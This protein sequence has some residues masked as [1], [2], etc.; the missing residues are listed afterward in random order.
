MSGSTDGPGLLTMSEVAHA[1]QMEVRTLKRLIRMGLFP[2]PLQMSPGVSVWTR[3]DVAAHVYRV[4][5]QHRFRVAKTPPGDKPEEKPKGQP[6]HS[7]GQRRPFT[8]QLDAEP[9]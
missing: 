6:R 5:N 1:L 2:A 8:G 9:S 7:G 4:A 3:E